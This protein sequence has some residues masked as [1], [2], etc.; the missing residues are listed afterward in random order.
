MEIISR[1]RAFG[2]SASSSEA[3]FDN[4]GLE[5]EYGG[6]PGRSLVVSLVAQWAENRTDILRIQLSIEKKFSFSRASM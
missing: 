3:V 5:N 6:N 1:T 4:V 2:I